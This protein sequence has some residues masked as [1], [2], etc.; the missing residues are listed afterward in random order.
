MRPRISIRGCVLRSVPRFCPRRNN[1]PS[2]TI[3]LG[4]VGVIR[5][6]F[7]SGISQECFNLSPWFFVFKYTRLRRFENDTFIKIHSCRPAQPTYQPKMKKWDNFGNFWPIKL[8]FCMQAPFTR[9]QAT[10]SRIETWSSPTLSKP[11]SRIQP[12]FCADQGF[13]SISILFIH[14]YGVIE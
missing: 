6:T 11:F 5:T 14:N 3:I 2:G 4:W 7:K 12:D 9:P 10:V 1:I 13:V 8:K